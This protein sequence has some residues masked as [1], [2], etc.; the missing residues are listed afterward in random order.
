MTPAGVVLGAWLLFGGT[1]LLLGSPPLR[2]LLVRRLGERVFTLVYT[3]IAALTLTLL[4]AAVARFGREGA[5]GPGLSA[6]PA[7]AWALGAVAFAGAAL[8]AAGL[9]NYFRSPIAFLRRMLGRPIDSPPI[10]LRAPS[11]VERITRHPF[12]VGV[13]LLMGAHA[14]LASTLA[15][16]VFFAGFVVLALAG[17]PLQDRKLRAQHGEVYAGYMATTSALPFAAPAASTAGPIGGPALVAPLLVAVGVA[18]LHPLWRIGNG[19]LLAILVAVFGL[20]AV[21]RQFRLSAA[22]RR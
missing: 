1:H 7:A 6:M 9:I 2:H 17:I 11:A 3:A 20:Y 8:A 13:A 22:A 19:A 10:V 18:A 12:F 14:L 5:P 4:A 21:A 15:G 16:A